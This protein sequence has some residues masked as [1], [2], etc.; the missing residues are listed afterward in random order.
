MSP[1]A[2]DLESL[3]I[4]LREK[5]VKSNLKAKYEEYL[6]QGNVLLSPTSK[7]DNY[8][9]E[10]LVTRKVSIHLRAD[11]HGGICLRIR[12]PRKFRGYLGLTSDPSKDEEVRLEG[13]PAGY[14]A[15]IPANPGGVLYVIQVYPGMTFE[16]LSGEGAGENQD[17][18]VEAVGWFLDF[19]NDRNVL[20]E[21]Q[22]WSDSG[23]SGGGAKD[24]ES[25][26]KNMVNPRF[27]K[28]SLDGL[29]DTQFSECEKNSVI[30][31]SK[32]DKDSFKFQF[33]L[34]KNSLRKGDF[35]YLCKGAVVLKLVQ[36]DDFRSIDHKISGCDDFLPHY[37]L[38]AEAN[39]GE[40][41]EDEGLKKQWIPN[42]NM[43][44]VGVPESSINDFNREILRPY[45]NT[46]SDDLLK[47]NE[48]LRVEAKYWWLQ[49][50]PETW[51]LRTLQIGQEESYSLYNEKGNRRKSET[52]FMGCREG[53]ML[54]GF[55]TGEGKAVSILEVTKVPYLTKI[56]LDKTDE[57]FFKKE[58]D[59]DNPVDGNDLQTI[60]P[61]GSEN[62]GSLFPLSYKEYVEFLKIAQ[63]KNPKKVI[64]N[65]N[66]KESNLPS[67]SSAP[68][69]GR[70]RNW[71]LFGAPGT[72]KSFKINKEACR[73]ENDVGMY[74]AGLFEDAEGRDPHY[75]RV[76]FY[77][78]YSY[79]QFVG[80][81]KPVMKPVAEGSSKEEIS[82]EFVPGPFLRVLVNALNDNDNKDWCL[83]IEEI[84]RANAAAVFGDVFQLL[85][86]NSK[87]ESEYS[88]AVSEDVKRYLSKNLNGTG[89]AVLGR[90]TGSEDML[91]IPRNMYLWATMNSADQ[92]V[93][94][95]DTAFKR[96]WEFEYVDK[97][98]G[99]RYCSEWTVFGATDK[100][101]FWD[102]IRKFLNGLLEKYGVN[103]D[104]LMGPFFVKPKAKDNQIDSKQF[105]SKVLMYL[106][107]D[108]ARMCRVK[109][110]GDAINSYS[111]LVTEWSKQG[112]GIF[113]SVVKQN[114]KGDPLNTLFQNDSQKFGDLNEGSNSPD[115]VV[116]GENGSQG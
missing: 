76:T 106:W 47:D 40:R 102:P 104:K 66:Q 95:M 64:Q 44:F 73:R 74:E 36:I 90:M 85:D 55:V 28:M 17:R 15:I 96:R 93:F 34:L 100:R 30:A 43:V 71:L 7:D 25:G 9:Y 12:G 99:S 69:I 22:K 87:G 116:A 18:L 16:S 49:A 5:I 112:L 81:Y 113:E 80:T 61:R 86:R 10:L 20:Q 89:K 105:A 8:K 75:E 46:C 83:I 107:E 97:D 32:K 68:E 108:A 1:S 84:N 21:T 6:V 70:P 78:T 57:L 4:Q 110:F 92:G 88:I 53:D 65:M 67:T 63:E 101:Y 38:I 52:A 50:K 39:K 41:Y 51:N 27:W 109:I 62:N 111:Q 94:P 56:S 14:K 91:K 98:E 29:N 45:F 31:F 35:V 59:L 33:E 37:R 79:A 23:A 2:E 48:N 11:K 103:E 3:K 82:Y 19:L 58:V 114:D 26:N 60:R 54:I 24:A 77:P 42:E 72:G 13:L 115:A